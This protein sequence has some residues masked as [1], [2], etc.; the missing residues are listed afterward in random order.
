MSHILNNKAL[1]LSVLISEKSKELE[2]NTMRTQEAFELG[3]VCFY[4]QHLPGF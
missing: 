4:G 1:G 2:P 3:H